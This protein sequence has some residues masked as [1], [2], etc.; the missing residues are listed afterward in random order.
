MLY[1]GRDDDQHH[2]GVAI[3]LKKGTEKCFMEWKPGNSRLIKIK[4]RG[5]QISTTIIQCY[6]PTCTK[7]SDEEVKDRFYEQLQAELEEI[8]RHDMK[9]LMGD[10]NAEETTPTMREPWEERAVAP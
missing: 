7:N 3:I 4:L 2:E 10:I 9:I 6:V 8:P 5:K 1:S